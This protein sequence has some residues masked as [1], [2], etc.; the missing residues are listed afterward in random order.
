MSVLHSVDHILQLVFLEVLLRLSLSMSPGQGS[1]SDYV[2]SLPLGCVMVLSTKNH[3]LALQNASM[4]RDGCIPGMECEP[5]MR[6]AHSNIDLFQH[7][8]FVLLS[9]LGASP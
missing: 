9:C 5:P 6:F 1:K 8:G 2:L 3:L 7:V 4:S